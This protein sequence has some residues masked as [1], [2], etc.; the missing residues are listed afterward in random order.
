MESYNTQLSGAY[1]DLI[2]IGKG[3]AELK[4]I[5]IFIYCC[6]SE[7]LHKGTYRIYIDIYIYGVHGQGGGS[8]QIP[9]DLFDVGG[10]DS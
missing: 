5:L 8:M 2:Q 3:S 7:F 9:R 10:T 4:Y 6:V 1:L